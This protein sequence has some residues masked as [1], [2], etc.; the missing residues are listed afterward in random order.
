MTNL[1]KQTI[2][3][4]RA[5]LL[6]RDGL[7][8]IVVVDGIIES[9]QLWT[10]AGDNTSSPEAENTSI[11]DG[12]GQLA[13]SGMCDL[14]SRLR[15]PGLTRKGT[16]ASESYAALSSGFTRVLCA[17]DTIPAIDSV[18]TVQLIKQRADAADGAQILPIAALTI[19]LEGE[20]LSE[21]ATLQ[22]TGCPVAGQADKPL[23]NNNVLFSAM[24]Y[25]ASFDMPLF[26][27]ARDAEL[28]ADGCAHAGAMATR[29]G[30]PGIP[31]ASETVALARLI[32][33]SYTHLTLPTNRE[34]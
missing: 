31:V 5:R 3:V 32:A 22:S 4:N 1:S 13:I 34:V 15:E 27:T 25:A 21:L 12:N 7:Y 9:I 18:A 30:L 8:Q 11:V 28:G 10:E 26:M 17:P 33:V 19:G 24:E 20:Q 14:Y 6:D 2:V 23:K 16:I 29:L